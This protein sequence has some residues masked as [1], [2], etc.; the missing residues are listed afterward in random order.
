M[1]ADTPEITIVPANQASCVDLQ[2]VFGNRGQATDC[3]C[4][5]YKLAPNEAFSKF[6]RTERRRR[7]NEQTECG[8]PASP[9]TSGLVAYLAAEP[10]GWCAVE[11]RTAYTGLV[12]VYRVPWTGRSEDKMDDTVWAVTCLFTRAGYRKQGVSYALAE[13]AVD[14]ARQRNARALEAYPMITEPGQDVTWGELSV[15]T[16]GVFAA[17]GLEEVIRPTPRRVVTRIDFANSD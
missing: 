3:Q 2:T 1:T 17:A 13:A 14:F 9:T 10:V 4:Q 11:R 6:P 8:N 12:R 7:L 15:G 16:V 5:R